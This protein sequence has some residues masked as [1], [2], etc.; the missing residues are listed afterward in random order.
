MKEL[1]GV[2]SPSQPRFQTV[3]R[4]C[5]YKR[6]RVIERTVDKIFS[7]LA[8]SCP[9]LTVVILKVD[10]RTVERYDDDGTH[11]FLR[12]KQIDLHGQTRV[13]G[14]AEELHMVKH[15]E[16]CAEILESDNFGFPSMQWK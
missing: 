14:M 10:G 16:P 7:S 5:A 12:S 6:E 2:E 3:D 11:P 1:H 4:V 8:A 13:V 9:D 15:C